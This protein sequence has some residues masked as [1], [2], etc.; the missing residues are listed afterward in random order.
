MI[1]LVLQV[2]LGQMRDMGMTDTA[3]SIR[4]LIATGGNVE[5]AIEYMCVYRP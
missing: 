3:R 1:W 5:A 2:Q 4:A